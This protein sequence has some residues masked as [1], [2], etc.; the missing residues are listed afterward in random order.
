VSD[1][2]GLIRQAQHAFHNISY[3][4]TDERKYRARAKR[5]ANRV[6]RKYP[7]SIEAIQ[8]R[9][10]LDRLNVI[11]EMPNTAAAPGPV[12]EALT[13]LKNHSATDG[14]AANKTTSRPPP[15]T[16]E[17]EWRTLMQRFLD[18]PNNKKKYLAIGLF[19][20]V[21]F[22]GG[23]FFIGALAIL[24]AL[25]PALLKKHLEHLLWSLGSE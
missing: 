11:Y 7:A 22:P 23:I 16:G 21:V 19:L 17:S 6:I 15:E 24:Y 14:H 2:D 9:S 1:A 3:G 18:L 10:I 20:V 13:F 25:R 12:Q 8:G 5:Y 4:S